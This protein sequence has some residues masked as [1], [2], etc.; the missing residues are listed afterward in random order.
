MRFLEKVF[1]AIRDPDAP[2]WDEDRVEKL[3][4]NNDVL[5]VGDLEALKKAVMYWDYVRDISDENHDSD[6]IDNAERE[7]DRIIK[8]MEKSLKTIKRERLKVVSRQEPKWDEAK[9]ERILK[10]TKEPSKSDIKELDRAVD[11][12]DY[13]NEISDP[14]HDADVIDNVTK[15]LT[16]II[17]FLQDHGV[18]LKGEKVPQAKKP[19]LRVVSFVRR[20]LNARR[21]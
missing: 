20:I 6:V 3:L 7:M 18:N 1:A 17:D 9:V 11:Y 5:T 12:W 13:I 2:D 10:S 14:K 4:N 8:R 21:P 19:H 16:R 15:E